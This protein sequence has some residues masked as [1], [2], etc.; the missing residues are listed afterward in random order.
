MNRL[1]T[2]IIFNTTLKSKKNQEA[3]SEKQYSDYVLAKGLREFR[4]NLTGHF[5][6]FLLIA[7]GIFFCSI[8]L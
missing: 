5:K 1:W 6:D 7:V 2:R 3:G 4:I 8:R